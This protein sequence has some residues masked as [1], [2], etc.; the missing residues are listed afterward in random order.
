[1]S[2]AGPSYYTVML[3]LFSS[4]LGSV[5]FFVFVFVFGV[6]LNAVYEELGHDSVTVATPGLDES[7]LTG[8]RLHSRPTNLIINWR[9]IPGQHRFGG[10]RRY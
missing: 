3:V 7:G 9:L 6:R 5:V 4:Q 10:S 8:G 1:M 2:P